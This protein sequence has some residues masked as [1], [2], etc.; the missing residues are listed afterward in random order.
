L[1]QLHQ[2]AKEGQ[3]LAF[4]DVCEELGVDLL[5]DRDLEQGAFRS[6]LGDVQSACA[7]ISRVDLPFDQPLALETAHDLRGHLDIGSSLRRQG[8][9]E[10]SA[11]EAG[12]V[13]SMR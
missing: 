7:R 2:T 4:G 8:N 10:P 3:G 13:I 5:D 9:L 6:A 1:R 12:P 11:S